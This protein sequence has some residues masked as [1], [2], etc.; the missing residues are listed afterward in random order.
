MRT[1]SHTQLP[2]NCL[3]SF[4]FL[5]LPFFVSLEMSLFPAYFCA[6]TVFSLYGE[7]VVRLSVSGGVFYLV[8][9][10]WIFYI[11]LCEILINQKIKHNRYCTV[12]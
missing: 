4:L 9:T 3:R 1:D 11:R 10:D 8:N 6:I 7:Y 2:D 5:F 12:S